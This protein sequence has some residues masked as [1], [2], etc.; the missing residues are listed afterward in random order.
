MEGLVQ[1]QRLQGLEYLRLHSPLLLIS[2]Q[3][4]DNIVKLG[5]GPETCNYKE[6][7]AESISTA[8]NECVVNNLYKNNALKLAD[9]LK[10]SNGTELTIQHIEKEFLNQTI[11]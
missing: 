10:N 11:Y 2:S 4:V 1:W 7:T 6:M 9:K 5:L 8:I 3:I